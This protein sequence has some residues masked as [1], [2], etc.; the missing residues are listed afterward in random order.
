MAC[1]RSGSSTCRAGGRPEPSSGKKGGAHPLRPRW[2]LHD[3]PRV[4][5]VSVPFLAADPRRALLID[6]FRTGV[7]AVDGRRRVRAALAGR[8]AGRVSAFAAG[9]AAASMMQGALDA[10]GTDIER[11]LV[12]APDATIPAEL[13]ARPGIRCLEA[14]HPR[15]D[16]RS[17][18]AGEALLAFAAAT[19]A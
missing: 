2:A 9:K 8:A 13:R 6:L 5:K 3:L 1:G 15:P 12:V 4:K 7:A 16:E 14:G 11:G 17:L 10:L 19:P 18:A